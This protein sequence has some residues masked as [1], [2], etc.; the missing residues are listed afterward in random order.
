[1]I[2]KM[3]N[4]FTTNSYI[5]LE[6]GDAVLVDPVGDPKEFVAELEGKSAVCRGIVYTHGHYDHIVSAE[7]FYKQFQMPLHIHSM[8]KE[9]FYDPQKN[10]SVFFSRNFSLDPSI[11][12]ITMEDGETLEFGKVKIRIHHTPGH[13]PGSVCL[14]SGDDLY[15]GDTLFEGSIGRTD[16]PGSD[17]SLMQMSLKK[18]KVME[19]G[20]QVHPGHGGSSTIEE[21]L[22]TNHYLR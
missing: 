14:E 17:L 21:E 10:L 2:K 3:I 15:T 16:F 20:L 5:L 7:D 12:I 8:D 1:M 19:P 11:P 4:H 6:D 22:R 18:L 9:M 13:T